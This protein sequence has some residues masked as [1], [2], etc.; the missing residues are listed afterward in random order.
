MNARADSFA[1]AM[2]AAATSSAPAL[3]PRA[4][5]AALLLHTVSANDRDWL[6][7]QLSADERRLMDPLL[8]ELRD[9]GIPIERELLAEVA[10]GGADEVG[11]L[12][13]A[14]PALVARVLAAEPLDLIARVFALGPWSWSGAVLTA[15]SPVR[16]E[17]L[18]DRLTSANRPAGPRSL[19]D[20]RLLEL[21]QARVQQST[22]ASTSLPYRMTAQ[23]R[24]AQGATIV[25]G[26]MRRWLARDGARR[27]AGAL[28]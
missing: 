28:E 25:P 4:R 14:D 20:A 9:L 22:Q 5:R 7:A 11:G 17:Q 13:G 24:P 10:G 15:M 8:A 2:T 16:R 26:W 1:M 18:R 3:Q 12:A 6:L 27:P 19:L 21:V 23:P